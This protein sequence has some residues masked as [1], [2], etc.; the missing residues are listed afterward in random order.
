MYDEDSELIIV[1]VKFQNKED[2]ELLDW[3]LEYGK[4]DSYPFHNARSKKILFCLNRL[5][6]IIDGKINI[7]EG[8]TVINP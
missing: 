2:I 5:R 7:V 8:K 3:V 1:Q 4:G 6:D